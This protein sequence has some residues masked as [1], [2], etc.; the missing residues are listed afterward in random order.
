MIDYN[1]MED[2]NT[3]SNEALSDEDVGQDAMVQDNLVSRKV[4]ND[5]IDEE[6]DLEKPEDI[7]PQN[8]KIENNHIDEVVQISS[9]SGEDVPSPREN[10][11]APFQDDDIMKDEQMKN[12]MAFG[13]NQLGDGDEDGEAGFDGYNP[14]DYMNLNVSPEVKQLFRFITN[15]TPQVS[16]I[17]AV[18]KPFIPEYIPTVGEVDAY[19]K[20][21]KPDGQ[22]ETLGLF[23]IDEP[24]L[25]QTKKSE[26]DYLIKEFYMGDTQELEKVHSIENAHKNPKEVQSWIQTIDSHQNKKSAPSVIYSKKM[27]E[28]DNLLEPWDSDFEHVVNQVPLPAGDMTEVPMADLVKFTCMMLDVPVH[29]GADNNLIE[30]LHLVFTMY[31]GLRENQHF[32]Q[33]QEDQPMVNRLQL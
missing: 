2:Q 7:P 20:I 6:I 4:Y 32:Q 28:I 31:S 26:M 30:S 16:E 23:Q 25:N 22:P 19:L 24:A 17:D 3:A 18:L 9:E 21:P 13:Q 29:P 8:K 33:N 14:N 1:D 11:E 27:P 5:V 15:Y 12:K 10:E